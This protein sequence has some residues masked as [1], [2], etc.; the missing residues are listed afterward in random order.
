M[1]DEGSTR[2]VRPA[3]RRP[4]LGPGWRS[5][6]DPDRPPWPRRQ[7]RDEMGPAPV[8]RRRPVPTGRGPHLVRRNRRD[9]GDGGAAQSLDQENA[10]CQAGGN[11]LER[12]A[13]AGPES[14][15]PLVVPRRGVPEPQDRPG[16]HQAE[17]GIAGEAMPAGAATRASHDSRPATSMR[18][19]S[20]G[21]A[22][23]LANSQPARRG[24][25][26]QVAAGETAAGHPPRRPRLG[27]GAVGSTE[28]SSVGVARLGPQVTG[29][30]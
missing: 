9:L 27:A 26:W 15:A 13:P 22:P 18:L 29:D 14:G 2:P 28:S 17:D 30:G 21:D 11:A 5:V 6:W 4:L 24:P 25:Y 8:T 3:L 10:S 16:A 7:I 12:C 1:R 19:F 23:L 20:C